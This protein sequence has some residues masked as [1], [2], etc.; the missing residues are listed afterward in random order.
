MIERPPR[1]CPHCD[2]EIRSCRSCH[3]GIVWGRSPARRPWPLDAAVT[4]IAVPANV[5]L[6]PSGWKVIRGHVPHH[7]T[8]PDAA[9]WQAGVF[10]HGGTFRKG[11]PPRTAAERFSNPVGG[12]NRAPG[13]KAASE[14]GT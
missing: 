1:T 14:G 10:D 13:P 6:P 11:P 12:T 3:A 7:I 9:A 4:T 5:E 2:L 8:C